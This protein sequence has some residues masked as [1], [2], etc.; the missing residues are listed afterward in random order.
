MA[1][2][3]LD[4][5]VERDADFGAA[6]AAPRRAGAVFVFTPAAGLRRAAAAGAERRAGAA[7][8]LREAAAARGAAAFAERVAPLGSG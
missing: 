8:R 1:Y 6:L 2:R 4:V 3:R 5:L 7:L